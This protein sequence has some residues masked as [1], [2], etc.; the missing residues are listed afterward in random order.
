MRKVFLLPLAMAVLVCWAAPASAAVIFSDDFNRI[1]N[2]TVGNGWSERQ[3]DSDDVAISNQR[4]LIR[5]DDPDGAAWHTVTA[6]GYNNIVLKFDWD[7]LSGTEPD[8][9][10]Y[11]AWRTGSNASYSASA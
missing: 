9:T 10:F 2:N 6:T 4:L 8:D 5:A 7:E 3:D 11:V 1:D